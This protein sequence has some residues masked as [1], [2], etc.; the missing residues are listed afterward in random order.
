LDHIKTN[1]EV[2]KETRKWFKMHSNRGTLPSAIE[3]GDLKRIIALQFQT[4]YRRL[5]YETSRVR[6]LRIRGIL[7]QTRCAGTPPPVKVLLDKIKFI[8]T[9]ENEPP[10]LENW[11]RKIITEVVSRVLEEL[12][13][14]PFTGLT[15]KSGVKVT[16]SACFEYKVSE[17]GTAQAVNDLVAEAEEGRP[18]V[19]YDLTNLRVIQELTLPE[20]TPGEYIFWRSLE[21]CIS[22]TPENLREVQLV[23]VKEPGKARSVTKGKACLKIVLDVVNGICSWP[24]AKGFESSA[25]GMLKE[26][27]GWNLFKKFFSSYRDITFDLEKQVTWSEDHLTKTV[28][29]FYRD[30]FASSTDYTTATDFMRYDIAEIIGD[31]W[32]QKVGIPDVLRGLVRETCY[33][34][35]K[36]YFSATGGLENYGQ[37]TPEKGVR[38]VISRRGVLM[39]DPL[40]KVVLH[41]LN[42]AVRK[43]AALLEDNS[44][45]SRCFSNP[46]Q[47]SLL[48][49]QQAENG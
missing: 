40:T 31:L 26:A 6:I 7:N 2:L 20:M 48:I 46:A 12:P 29:R 41:L 42:I 10:P 25:S 34:P 49:H 21:E 36:I 24:L 30:V 37:P 13:D 27:H 45:L 39:G 33:R 16:S 23:V 47:A 32:M 4:I 17:E 38:Y 28:K 19:I 8:K 15:T 18:V 3:A 14:E 44:F 11:R 22:T 5:S 43:T 35:R 1:Y 9:V